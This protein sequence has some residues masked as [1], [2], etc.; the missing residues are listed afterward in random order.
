MENAARRVILLISVA[1]TVFVVVFVIVQLDD[2]S[3]GVVLRA[4]AIL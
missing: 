2:E 3:P 4:R 1:T